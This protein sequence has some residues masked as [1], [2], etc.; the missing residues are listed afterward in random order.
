VVPAPI[1]RHRANAAVLAVL[2]LGTLAPRAAA[3]VPARVIKTNRLRDP[4]L[5]V[6]DGELTTEVTYTGASATAAASTGDSIG[7]EKGLTF[8]L[9]TCVAYHLYGATPLSSCAERRGRPVVL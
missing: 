2:A 7:L 5:D 6:G 1:T 8:L 4:S 3:N 9:R